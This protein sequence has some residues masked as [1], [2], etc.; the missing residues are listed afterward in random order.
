MNDTETKT[1][2]RNDL[3]KMGMDALDKDR[4]GEIVISREAGGVEFASAVEVMEFAK[5]MSVG[6]ESIPKHLQN[7]PGACLRI[8]FQAIEWKVSPYAVADQSYSVGGRMAYMAQL[9]HAIVEA[10]APLKKLLEAEFSGEGPTRK[11][12]I[13][14]TFLDGEVRTYESPETKDIKVKNSPLWTGDLDQQLFYFGSRAWGRRWVPHVLFGIYT[15]QEVRA[16]MAPVVEGDEQIDPK[17]APLKDR[18]QGPAAGAEGHQP[19]H[20]ERE[21]RHIVPDSKVE[22]LPA[23]GAAPKAAAATPAPD[24]KSR[25]GVAAKPNAASKRGRGGAKPSKKAVENASN[26]AEDAGRATTLTNPANVMPKSAAS[27]AADRAQERSD[28][29]KAKE[30]V[31]ITTPKNAAEYETMVR[32]YTEKATDADNLEGRWDGEREQRDELSVPIP[33]RKELE[34]LIADKCGALR[35]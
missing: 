7:N 18:L 27:A 32:A 2:T 12:K 19:G 1:I 20:A 4:A 5:L 10:R 35:Q 9:I 34:R 30:P 29:T 8:V 3:A 26:K 24:G 16:G 11:I 15:P 14:G 6:G 31:T 28:A 21:L 17:T 22:I 13:I 33:K 23:E 25:T